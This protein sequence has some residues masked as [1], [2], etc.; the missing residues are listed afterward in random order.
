LQVFANGVGL[1]QTQYGATSPKDNFFGTVA[2]F[3][4]HTKAR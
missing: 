2:E 4:P 3:A 1:D